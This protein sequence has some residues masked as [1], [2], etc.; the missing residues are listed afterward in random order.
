MF[1]SGP[2]GL[3]RD[4]NKPYFFSIEKLWASL[5][6]KSQDAE[7]YMWKV[8][9]FDWYHDLSV[10]Y[11][12]HKCLFFLL[13]PVKATHGDRFMSFSYFISITWCKKDITPLLAHWSYVF[14]A[15]SHRI[16]RWQCIVHVHNA[17]FL[18]GVTPKITNLWCMSRNFQFTQMMYLQVVLCFFFVFFFLFFFGG[19]VVPQILRVYVRFIYH[20]HLLLFHR[21]RQVNPQYQFHG[22][23]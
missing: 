1:I 12:A 21:G 19:G 23:S 3:C 15:L 7:M 6:W 9:C 16:V 17:V 4:K 8:S 13:H 2:D 14:L 5:E 20:R 10:Q 18:C 22:T 11:C